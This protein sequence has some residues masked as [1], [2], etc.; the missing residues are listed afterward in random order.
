MHVR[1]NAKINAIREINSNNEIGIDIAADAQDGKANY[2]LIDYIKNS[3]KSIRNY[4]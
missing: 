4:S 2:E 3:R 1:P